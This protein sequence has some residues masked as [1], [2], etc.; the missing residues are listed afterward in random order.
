MPSSG[1]R[2]SSHH[3]SQR[4]QL[5]ETDFCATIGL[6]GTARERLRF[7]YLPRKAGSG[8]EKVSD[9]TAIDL[10]CGAGGLTLGMKR[11]GVRTVAAVE[12][13]RDACR[14]FGASFPDVTLVDDDIRNVDFRSY[15][16]IDLVVGGPPCQP[17]STGGKRMGERDSRDMLPEFVRAVLESRPKAFLMENV[18][19][20][21]GT[22][23]EYLM[24]TV[25]PLRDHYDIGEPAMVNAADHGVPQK[26]RRMLLTGYRR[27]VGG[28][29]KVPP[30]QAIVPASAAIGK[31]VVGEHN[32]S[33]VTYAKNPDIR[34]NPFDGQLFN[35]GGRGI[36]L[37]RPSP[38]ILASAGGNKTP[39]IDVA[40]LVPAYHA[41]LLAGGRPRSGTLPNARR[42]SVRECARLQTFPDDMVFHG[43]RSS[44][45]RQVG[46]AVLP[47]LAEVAAR[48]LLQGMCVV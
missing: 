36:D 13:D 41:H 38:T 5:T 39:F 25:R 32:P 3:G 21:A 43:R 47:V 2:R 26:R 34:P 18:P 17:W 1:L 15:A 16:N 29:F 20:L 48:A 10:F 42:I 12:Y 6:A 22:H 45:Y 19:G 37:A 27:D 9:I 14:T 35:G 44:Q 28:S 11:A 23:L 4:I 46:N 33:K 24:E 40:D 8:D 31:K 7:S 30:S